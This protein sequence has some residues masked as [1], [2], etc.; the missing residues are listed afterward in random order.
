[1][2]LALSMWFTKRGMPSAGRFFHN[3]K[4]FDM[5]LI[6]IGVVTTIISIY[7]FVVLIDY[8]F[9]NPPCVDDVCVAG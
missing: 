9:F 2:R 5:T 8:L 4:N 6:I 7:L 1:M 3:K